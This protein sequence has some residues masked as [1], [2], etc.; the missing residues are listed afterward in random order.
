M[1]WELL[2]QR[3]AEFRE[4]AIKRLAIAALDEQLFAIAE[5]YRAKAIP[6]RLKA[7]ASASE[8]ISSTRLASMGRIGELKDNAT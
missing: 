1:L 8:G 2:Q 5:N 4:I 7:P 3:F 6:L